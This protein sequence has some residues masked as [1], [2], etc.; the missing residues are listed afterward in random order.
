MRVVLLLPVALLAAC[1]DGGPVA[2]NDTTSAARNGNEA[3]ANVVDVAPPENSAAPGP[4]PP[5]DPPNPGE[6][7][8]LPD[9][10]TPISEAP[11]TE[12]SAQ[13]AANVVQSYYA[14]VESGRYPQA[15]RLWSDGGRASGMSAQAFAASFDRY[16]EYHANIGA[17]GEIEGAAGS[18]FV[19]VP[20]QVYG[21]LR[22]GEPFHM[23]GPVRLRR[24]NHVPGCSA[25]QL[26][27]RIAASGVR[28]RPIG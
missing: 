13:G 22:S 24:C 9:D 17:P 8:G 19:E 11:F 26:K 20:V 18:L 12:E 6:P 27:W 23:L 2:G 5:L 1:A 25:E 4:L 28:P 14:L 3:A 10:R 16:S 7:G 21:R 15:W